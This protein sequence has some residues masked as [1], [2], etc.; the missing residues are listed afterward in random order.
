MK[1]LQYKT[2]GNSLP[3]GKPYVYF[4]AHEKDFSLFFERISQKLL[5][6]ANCAIFYDN[7][8]GE[9]CDEE[10]R[11][12]DLLRMKLFVLPVTERFLSDENSIAM[13]EFR[14]AVKNHIPVL[15]I[16]Q[17]KGLE[18]RFNAVCGEMQM[19]SAIPSDGTEI[20]F[21][22]KLEKFLSAVLIGDDLAER[23]R[24][25]FDAYIFLSYR[26]KDR[27]Y[28]QE[29]IRLIHKNEFCRDIAIWYDEFLTPGENFND[30]IA[31][32]LDKSKIFALAVT[33]NLVNEK[34][35]V[36]DIEYP[37]AKN[38]EKPILPA[39]VVPT[40]REALK[41]H[42]EAIPDTVNAHDAPALSEALMQALEQIAIREN[43]TSP[44]HNFFIGLAYLSGIDVEIDRERALKLITSSAETELPEA[45]EKLASMYE[46]G[47]SVE[48]NREEELKWRKKLIEVLK[49]VYARSQ[50]VNDGIRLLNAMWALE[51]TEL[52]YSKYREEYIKNFEEALQFAKSLS[53][54][55]RI[56]QTEHAV[57]LAYT[58]LAQALA[59]SEKIEEAEIYFQK[60]LSLSE[61]L[62]ELYGTPFYLRD[63]ACS[64]AALGSFYSSYKHDKKRSATLHEKRRVIYEQLIQEEATDRALCDL[65]YTYKE[66]A[67]IYKEISEFV[68]AEQNHQKLI[69]IRERIAKESGREEA[70]SELAAA[71]S[72]LARF[73]QDLNRNT[74]AEREHMISLQY[75]KDIAQ[76]TDSVFDNENLHFQ[77]STFIDFYIKNKT[78]IAAIPYGEELIRVA[79]RYASEKTWHNLIPGYVLSEAYKKNAEIYKA[80]GE[81]EKVLFFIKK[82]VENIEKSN[83]DNLNWLVWNY[84]DLNSQYQQ[85]G[86]YDEAEECCRRQFHY[87]VL[88]ARKF[89]LVTGMQLLNFACS[90]LTYILEKQGKAEEALR[91][92]DWQEI[93]DRFLSD[94]T[95]EL[96]EWA[97]FAEMLLQYADNC[98]KSERAE[99][100]LR[101]LELYNTMIEI[102]PDTKRYQICRDRLRDENSAEE[103]ESSVN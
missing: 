100:R 48:Y 44:E 84:M 53:E 82:N 22:E 60:S 86:L 21:D 73:Y 10:T 3:K 90:D 27:K 58:A 13:Q 64:Y 26:K 99:W 92:K 9:N 37:M 5:K 35:Y 6:T 36:M 29:L 59:H 70:P 67:E 12:S 88:S 78:P 76:K 14:F 42:Y 89:G 20:G 30:E 66:L 17:E 91:C 40:D 2:R 56:H 69:A 85:M 77:I 74:E 71:H 4:F 61:Q 57:R 102:S 52:R 87:A 41:Q 93:F 47:E 28:A 80:L 32:A 81:Q 101:V 19:L 11:F 75:Y 33:P 72:S 95:K 51:D 79:E 15:P 7:G 43:D 98:E 8:T 45:I 96:V 103:A 62:F 38:A 68:Q 97:K 94:E 46:T 24:N 49:K 65:A 1:Q 25:A 54:R 83:S 63:V 34:N 18:N 31:A 50:D 23:I 16:L 55:F 39:E